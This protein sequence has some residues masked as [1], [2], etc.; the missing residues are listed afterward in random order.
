VTPR[1]LASFSS[2]AEAIARL[3]IEAPDCGH[4]L[5][6]RRDRKLDDRAWDIGRRIRDMDEREVAMQVLSP[7]PMMFCYDVPAAAMSPYLT[8]VNEGIAEFVRERPD[9]FAGLA[10]VA[11][12]DVGAAVEGVR[13]ACESLGLAGVEIGSNAAGFD[14]EDP[15]FDPFWAECERLGAVVFIHPESAPGFER[16]RADQLAAST[17]YPSETGAI[18]AKLLM[19]GLFVRHPRLK[20]VLAHGGGTLPWL[21]ARLDTVW[22]R[23]PDVHAKLP[24]APSAFA[25]SFSFDTL[26]FE[27]ANL[28]YIA[29]RVGA[30]RLVV[31]TDYPFTLG[32]DRPG[33]LV[34]ATPGFDD[35]GRA[36]VLSGNARALLQGLHVS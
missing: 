16:F 21:L 19:R 35:A 9:R 28:A 17:G 26:V 5:V 31:G 12:Q 27:Q 6:G 13:Y 3:V 25:R 18:A 36:A 4:L 34:R 14:V 23:F 1:R 7:V 33:S 11:L 29:A 8:T 22:S 15:R 20:V 24:S 10:G 32:E 30:D 2:E